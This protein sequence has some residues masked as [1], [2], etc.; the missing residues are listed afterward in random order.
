MPMSR[1]AI[2][3]AAS[4]AAALVVIPNQKS[5]GEP[6]RDASSNGWHPKRAHLMTRW[7]RDVSPDNVWPQYPRPQLVRHRW[8]NLN[9][10]WNYQITDKNQANIPG[11]H[12]GQI[13]VPFGIT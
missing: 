11:N 8:L 12:A 4:T 13:M 1:R 2:L 5:S 6:E 7:S 10:L 3:A 9:G